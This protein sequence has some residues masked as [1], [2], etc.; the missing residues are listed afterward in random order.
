MSTAH[1]RPPLCAGQGDLSP[2]GPDLQLL[3]ASAPSYSKLSCLVCS[4]LEHISICPCVCLSV[5]LMSVSRLL[6][7][8]AFWMS[9]DSLTVC[10]CQS[11]CSR[12][13]G[14]HSI[15]R[16]FSSIRPQHPHYQAFPDPFIAPYPS[17][18]T[19]SPASR[20]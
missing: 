6:W 1:R 19:R 5:S 7:E 15:L 20:V 14:G 16:K 9:S 13:R 11:I 4:F 18:L 2:V 10:V 17:S 12:L 3:S 8:E